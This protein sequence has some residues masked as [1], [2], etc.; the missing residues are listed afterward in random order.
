MTTATHRY[1]AYLQNADDYTHYFV[2]T[3]MIKNVLTRAHEPVVEV[4]WGYINHVAGRK[5]YNGP[6]GTKFGDTRHAASYARKVALGRVA[7]GFSLQWSTDKATAWPW[8]DESFPVDMDGHKNGGRTTTQ[9]RGE[10]PA[11]WTDFIAAA[12][13][14]IATSVTASVKVSG[15]VVPNVPERVASLKAKFKAGLPDKYKP[16][17]EEVTSGKKQPKQ[18]GKFKLIDR[19]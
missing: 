17:R 16:K 19:K 1:A 2:W 11:G 10:E 6:A 9:Y 3:S 4:A 18:R 12:K 14:G 7:D 5:T 8:M 15:G 13:F